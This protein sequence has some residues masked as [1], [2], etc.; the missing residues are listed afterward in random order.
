MRDI[1]S[2]I[3]W[4]DGIFHPLLIPF[5]A[6]HLGRDWVSLMFSDGKMCF[7]SA[8]QWYPLHEWPLWSLCGIGFAEKWPQHMAWLLEK[9]EATGLSLHMLV[10]ILLLHFILWSSHPISSILQFSL[11]LIL[12]LCSECNFFSPHCG[13]HSHQPPPSHIDTYMP[14]SLLYQ[15]F[16]FQFKFLFPFFQTS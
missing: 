6:S 4:S 5:T 1:F 11:N 15:S 13:C 16:D 8:Q 9:R 2:S 7:I 3:V 12:E 14:V 10:F